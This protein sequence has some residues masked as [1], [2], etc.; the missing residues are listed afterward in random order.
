MFEDMQWLIEN[1]LR[2]S[3][4]RLVMTF[5][6][7]YL[8]SS[9]STAYNEVYMFEDKQWL[10]ENTLRVSLYRLVMTFS[11]LYL[12]SSIACAAYI[13]THTYIGWI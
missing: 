12:N 2:V 6:F 5:N 8:N 3:L 13:N 7:L 11:F 9:T 10:I 4:Y 1:T